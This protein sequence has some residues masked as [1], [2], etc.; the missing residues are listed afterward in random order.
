MCWTTSQQISKHRLRN[1]LI[2]LGSF[3]PVFRIFGIPTGHHVSNIHL[4]ILPPQLT[5]VAAKFIQMPQLHQQIYMTTREPRLVKFSR[6][7]IVN[8][9]GLLGYRYNE[10]GSSHGRLLNFYPH[11]PLE[12]CLLVNLS[13]L[14]SNKESL[15]IGRC[16]QSLKSYTKWTQ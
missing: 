11:P 5:L 14:S 13:V 15:F 16:R 7:K 10:T 2:W 8:E 6:I 12:I 3:S 1:T 9:T 4:T